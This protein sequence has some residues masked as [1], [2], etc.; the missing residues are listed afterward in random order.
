MRPDLMEKWSCL[1]EAIQNIIDVFISRNIYLSNLDF[2][3]NQWPHKYGYVNSFS[4]LDELRRRVMDSKHAFGLHIAFALF[5]I[6]GASR[7]IIEPVEGSVVV[8]DKTVFRASIR[9]TWDVFGV[10]ANVV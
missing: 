10:L 8:L 3:R 5:L 2:R 4:S 9:R 1:E 6:A 7:L